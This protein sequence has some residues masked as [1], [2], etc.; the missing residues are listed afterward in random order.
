MN[1]VPNI[2]PAGLA[3]AYLMLI[4]PLGILLLRGVPLL[5]DTGIAVLRMTVQ[6]LFVGL[7]LQ[8][9]FALNHPGVNLLW[10]LV[11]VLVADASILKGCGLRMRTLGWPLF[12]AILAGTALPSLVFTGWILRLGNPLD[13]R[14]IIPV[15]GMILG[16]C[17][18]A[19]IIGLDHFYTSLRS[20]E[21][22][23]LL[24]LSRGATRKKRWPLS[25]GT[26]SKPPSPPVW[27]AWRRSV[28]CPCP[29]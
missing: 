23:Y 8:V 4:V 18:R 13:A 25:S 5:R 26:P 14:Y 6:L 2:S 11:M 3:V 21:K 19:D 10:L 29:A 9:V 22:V 1:E 27:P 12:W 28:W 17:L 20:R 24:A 16:N 7:Y 15:G